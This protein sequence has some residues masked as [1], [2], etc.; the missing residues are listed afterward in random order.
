MVQA[1]EPW[2]IPEDRQAGK[3]RQTSHGWWIM[4]NG[5]WLVGGLALITRGEKIER[6]PVSE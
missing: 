5:S 1:S 4:Q 3:T 2:Q 6:D